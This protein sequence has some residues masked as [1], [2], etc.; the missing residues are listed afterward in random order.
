ME[1]LHAAACRKLCYYDEEEVDG[2]VKRSIFLAFLSCVLVLTLTSTGLG[3]FEPSSLLATVP[4]PLEFDLGSLEKDAV[5]T[6]T[7]LVFNAFDLF[8]TVSLRWEVK[9]D[10][11]WISM[12]PSSGTINK[13]GE[14]N[15]TTVTVKI[16]TNGL[17]DG[18]YE[19]TITIE[20]NATIAPSTLHGFVKFTIGIVPPGPVPPS[21]V[22]NIE[23][24]VDLNHNGL[25]D[26]NE[27]IQALS[28]WTK[29]QV[30]PGTGTTISDST[31]L[32]L[33]S[34]WIK[35]QVIDEVLHPPKAPREIRIMTA[36][37]LIRAAEGRSLLSGPDAGVIPKNGDT[38]VVMPGSYDLKSG[39]VRVTLENLVVRS[40]EGASATVL[41]GSET[42][43]SVEARG[44]TIGGAAPNQGFRIT[45]GSSCVRIHVGD[46]V[47]IQNNLITGCGSG[48]LSKGMSDADRLTIINNTISENGSYA[49]LGHGNGISIEAETLRNLLIAQNIVQD[50]VDHGLF[51]AGR[52]LVDVN[53]EPIFSKE[54]IKIETLLGQA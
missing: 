14:A 49:L 10:K 42:I 16:D 48:I 39:I 47:T 44:V 46:L 21:P 22:F 11:P 8:E 3:Q 2:E 29:G 1:L 13:A 12:S 7:F 30:V 38:L 17:S 23:Q 41:Q 5:I 6:R 35:G 34:I 43:I 15:G 53:I 20:S 50:S 36:E 27:M 25:I 32:S 52:R 37:D 9:T 19:A 40:N 45:G 51:L 33:L 54:T 24:A 4:F 18:D 26:D 31:I 28:W